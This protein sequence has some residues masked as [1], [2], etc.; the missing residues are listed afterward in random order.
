MGAD[1]HPLRRPVR[2]GA[3]YVTFVEHPARVRCGPGLALA[4][5]GSGYRRAEYLQPPL[6]VGGCAAGVAAWLAGAGPGWLAAAATLGSVVPFTLLAMRPTYDRLM[7]PGLD[8][9][10]DVARTLLRR[11]GRLHAVR[12]ALGATAFAGFVWLKPGG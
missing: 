12:T 11:W 10:S 9:G 6:A 4:E 2:G 1:R 5:F 3:A 7:A 8:A